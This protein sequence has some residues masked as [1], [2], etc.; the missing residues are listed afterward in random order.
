MRLLA[1]RGKV[2]CSGRRLPP[3]PRVWA[4]VLLTAARSTELCPLGT[5]LDQVKHRWG[6]QGPTHFR[7]K[8]KVTEWN[9]SKT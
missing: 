7:I 8:R 6:H 1:G 5:R 9:E 4:E 3:G 2:R